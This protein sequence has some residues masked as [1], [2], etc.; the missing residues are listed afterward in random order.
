MDI[1]HTQ[2]TA[3]EQERAAIDAF[4]RNLAD[5]PFVRHQLLPALRWVHGRIG[6]ISPGAINYLSALSQVPPA[7]IYGVA[8]FYT[9]LSCKPSSRRVLHVCDD[10][11]CR[12]RGSGAL[13]EGLVREFAA[14]GTDT[15]GAC[16]KRST[17]LGLCE[18]APAAFEQSAGHIPVE[19]AEGYV[20]VEHAVALLRR[21]TARGRAPAA[22]ALERTERWSDVPTGQLQLSEEL[23]VVKTPVAQ[24]LVSRNAGVIDPRDLGAYIVGGG[25]LALKRARSRGRDWV[26]EELEQANLVGRGGAGFKTATK[27]KAVLA[28]TKGANGEHIEPYVVCNADESEPG[29]FKDRALL[30]EDPFSLVEAVAMA[31]FCVG[32]KRAFIYI[33]GEFA[34]GAHRLTHAIESAQSAGWFAD[35]SLTIEV[36]RGG[37]A[38]ICGEETALL[39]SLEGRRGEPRAKPPF[40]VEHGLFG[41]PTLINNVETLIAALRIVSDGASVWRARGTLQSA[42][43]RLFSICGAVSNPGVYELPLGTPLRT[44]LAQAGADLAHTQAV[45]LGGAAGTLLTPREFDVSLSFEGTRAAKTTLGSGAVI[46]LGDAHPLS[47]V[48]QGIAWFFRHESCGQCVPCREGTVRVDELLSRVRAGSPRGSWAQERARLADLGAVMRDASICGLGQ[49]AASAVESAFDRF[50]LWPDQKEEQP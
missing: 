33:R 23:S 5:A 4:V 32:A 18:Q 1:H 19:Q 8:T 48:L 13:L 30:E 31:A 10:V 3:S 42:G 46:V 41:H 21:A 37:G 14:E 50:G 22:G 34:L 28:H 25:M 39:N 2:Y 26:I 9:L 49:T 6:W 16:W 40:P 45:L 36:R 12:Q 7:D 38:Y 44:L 35:D 15:D 20:T 11:A 43:T 24:R 17:C 27:W 29:T 47:Y